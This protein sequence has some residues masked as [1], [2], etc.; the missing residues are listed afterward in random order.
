MGLKLIIAPIALVPHESRAVELQKSKFG[1]T[2]FNNPRSVTE[3]ELYLSTRTT[4]GAKDYLGELILAS[5]HDSDLVRVGT[6][7]IAAA[8]VVLPSLVLPQLDIPMAVKNG[9]GLTSL[10]SPFAWLLVTQI[11]PSLILNVQKAS[12]LRTDASQMERIC[13]HEAGHFLVGYLSGLRTSEYDIS[14]DI[15][16]G[17][18]I[19]EGSGLVLGNLLTCALAGCVAETLR[20]GDS[21][22]G[23]ADIPIALE[24]LRRTNVSRSEHIGYLR[25]AT[26]KALSLLRL[27]RDA[28]DDIAQSM[29]TGA[30]VRELEQL[31]EQSVVES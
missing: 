23:K 30:S 9:L 28:L 14:G 19:D 1:S 16:S 3:N 29:A 12:S 5:G 10:F 13:Y 17:T 31:I 8:A 15:D 18:K 4:F 11:A 22:G 6:I 21:S 24:A 7:G 27:H 2:V 25:W 20:F 26:L